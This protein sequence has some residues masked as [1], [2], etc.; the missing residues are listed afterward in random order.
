MSNNGKFEGLRKLLADDLSGNKS[1]YNSVIKYAIRS[2]FARDRHEAEDGMQGFYLKMTTD[3]K[4]AESY[5]CDIDTSKEIMKDEKLRGW[6]FTCIS[7]HFRDL[8]RKKRNDGIQLYS[9]DKN[10][11]DILSYNQRFLVSSRYSKSPEEIAIENES[12]ESLRQD[13]EKLT[14]KYKRA[15]KSSYFQGFKEKEIAEKE[16]IPLG[17]VK[18]R[19]YGAKRKLKVLIKPHYEKAG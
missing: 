12:H 1:F 8:Q 17:T 10:L 4:K 6:L 9:E 2:R 18:S 13:I 19:I 5:S 7:N 3:E 14:P 11:M 16:D 15:I